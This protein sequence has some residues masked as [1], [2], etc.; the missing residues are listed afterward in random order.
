MA[1]QRPRNKA[2]GDRLSPDASDSYVEGHRATSDGADA[3]GRAHQ[4]RAEPRGDRRDPARC[5]RGRAVRAVVREG[6]RHRPADR[7]HAGLRRSGHGRA[8]GARDR[9]AALSHLSFDGRDRRGARASRRRHG[10]APDRPSP[11]PSRDD[12]PGVV[13]PASPRRPPTFFCDDVP[14]GFGYTA[15]VRAVDQSG[16]ASAWTA[17]VTITAGRDTAAPAIPTATSPT[18]T[19]TR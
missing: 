14:G 19:A 5:R 15:R 8:P 7:G 6:D 11:G 16:N 3:G 12:G 17:P 18:P 10:R 9:H 1:P 2:P 13:P 4:R